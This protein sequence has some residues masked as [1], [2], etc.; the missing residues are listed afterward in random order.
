MDDATEVATP[1]RNERVLA[2]LER[3]EIDV[4]VQVRMLGEGEMGGGLDFLH[5][6]VR[7]SPPTFSA[8]AGSALSLLCSDKQAGQFPS[9][10]WDLPR[11]QLS[12]DA[13]LIP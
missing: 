10:I 3:H 9:Q 13:R 7:L 5:P 8:R 11:P 6:L 4:V 2:L 12:I 1:T